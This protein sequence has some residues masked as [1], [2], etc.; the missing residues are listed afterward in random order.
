MAPRRFI[1]IIALLFLAVAGSANVASQPVRPG[2][3]LQSSQLAALEPA[4]CPPEGCA[5]GQRLSYR[6]S[7]EIGSYAPATEPNVAVCFY[8]PSDWLDSQY[9]PQLSGA[10]AV[11]GQAYAPYPANTCPHDPAPPA[12]Y[13]VQAGA[14]GAMNTFF[15]T[16]SLDI[17]FRIARGAV[18]PGSLLARVFQRDGAG[19]WTRSLQLFT[20]QVTIL[21]PAG[22]V[23]LGA[24]PT[25]CGGSPCYLN[26]TGDEPGGVGTGLKDAVDAADPAGGAVTIQVDGTIPLKSQMVEL[27]RAVRLVGAGQAGFTVQPGAACSPSAALLRFSAGGSL[28]YLNLDDGT[29]QDAGNRPLVIID[30]AQPVAILNSTLSGGSDAIRVSGAGAGAVRA[31]FNRISGNSRYALFWD[32]TSAADLDMLANNLDGNRAGSAVEC[33]AGAPAPAANRRVNHNYWGSTVP[34]AESHCNL[35]QSK[36]LGAPVAPNPDRP[37]VLAQR[38]TVTDQVQHAFGQAVS[39]VRS[40]GSNFD[41]YLVDHGNSFPASLPFYENAVSPL[42]CSHPYDVFLAG[43]APAGTTLDLSFSYAADAAC[44][45]AVEMSTFC[46][47]TGAPQ[48]YPLYWLD[49]AGQVTVGWN[50]TGQAPNGPGAAGAAGQTTSCNLNDHSIKVSLDTSGRPGLDADLG[51]TPFLVGMPIL[52]SFM[53]FA[54]DQTVSL[55]WTTVSEPNVSGFRMLRSLNANGPFEPVSDLIPRRGSATSG[56][57]YSFADGGRTNG[58]TNYY[59]LQIEMSGGGTTLSQVVSIM[60]NIATITPTWTAAPTLTPWPTITPYSFPTSIFSYPTRAFP[61]TSFGQTDVPAGPY[62]GPTSLFSLTQTQQVALLTPSATAT[63]RSAYPA[64]QGSDSPETAQTI[65]PTGTPLAGA[66]SGT[67]TPTPTRTPQVTLSR[68]QQIRGA[69]QYISLVMG[70]LASALLLGG[71]TWLMFGR[72]RKDDDQKE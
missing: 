24:S 39:F 56:M 58:I 18:T 61:T 45:A 66:R 9:A 4:G 50:T 65:T 52:K 15:F 1:L 19:V 14:E 41:L 5:A 21:P 40:G 2:P 69:S 51:Y 33:S 47:Q 6:L 46:E 13:A 71:L 60:P 34:G 17:R 44:V 20:P 16:D 72:R 55:F 53:P 3:R 23:Y 64:P 32:N 10:G 12:G 49:P 31:E 28:E 26:S 68:A 38:V 22:T 35:Q 70:I 8:A 25:A 54:S 30:S 27:N 63:P 29:C 42:P 7:F 43:Q 37:G 67:P 36:R 62:P 57:T 59:R 48:N 11:T